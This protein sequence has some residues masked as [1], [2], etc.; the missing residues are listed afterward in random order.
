MGAELTR[1]EVVVEL[2]RVPTLAV[3]VAAAAATAGVPEGRL[4]FV[5]LAVEEVLA[6]IC[7]HA[8]HGRPGPVQLALL[9]EGRQLTIQIADEGPAFDPTAAPVRSAREPLDERAAGGWGLELIREA[10]DEL[11]YRRER[12]RNVVSLVYHV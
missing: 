10:V 7:R 6:N 11:G 12:R 4:P 1:R 8:Y 5:E 2:A 9:Q 3:E